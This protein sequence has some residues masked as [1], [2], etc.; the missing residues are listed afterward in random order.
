MNDLA[1]TLRVFFALWPKHPER[2][3]FL[4]WQKT[5]AAAYGGRSMRAET[6]HVTL[7]FLGNVA[8]DRLPA[9]TQAAA[10]LEA[11][12]FELRFDSVR[13]WEH[14]HILYAAPSL[15]PPQLQ[16]W[17]AELRRALPDFEPEHPAYQPHVTLLRNVRPCDTPLPDLPPITWQI[18]GFVLLQSA[19]GDYR[20]LAEFAKITNIQ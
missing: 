4:H 14:N 20:P 17:E 10:K 12:R 3:P 2:E 9:L 7:V 1:H 16:R 19:S 8:Q 11:A 5:L 15:V 13:Y 6:L 18:N